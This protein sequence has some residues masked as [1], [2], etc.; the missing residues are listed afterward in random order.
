[1][2][3]LKQKVDAI[4]QSYIKNYGIEFAAFKK[5][6]AFKQ[7]NTKNEWAE[8]KGSDVMVRQLCEY[9]ETL[10]ALLKIGLTD[11]EFLEFKETKMQIWFGRTY[12]EF[13]AIQ[14]KL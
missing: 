10:Y 13:S 11:S 4:L 3:E 12:R 5:Q 8:M 7:A 14:G 6:Q 2:K 9:P 1:M